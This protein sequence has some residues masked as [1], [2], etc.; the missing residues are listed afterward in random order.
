M[1]AGGG[2]PAAPSPLPRDLALSLGFAGL[3]ASFMALRILGYGELWIDRTIILTGLAAL[4]GF[5]AAILTLMLLRL[6]NSASR[7]LRRALAAAGFGLCY[8]CALG[9]GYVIENRLFSGQ[10]EPHP[11]RPVMSLIFSSLQTAGMFAYS[12]PRYLFP[13]MLPLLMLTAAI[14]L[15]RQARRT[16]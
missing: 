1:K 3:A 5:L 16:R 13:W 11:D 4:A 12:A 15:E 2:M 6:G 14:V 8:L 9:G 10:W 7:L